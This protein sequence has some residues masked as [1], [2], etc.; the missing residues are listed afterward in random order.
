MQL[1]SG[2]KKTIER[3]Y[4]RERAAEESA[5]V[6]KLELLKIGG[7]DRAER[8]AEAALDHHRL[9]VKFVGTR[10]PKIEMQAPLLMALDDDGTR[11]LVFVQFVGHGVAV[12]KVVALSYGRQRNEGYFL[13][14]PWVLAGARGAV[15]LFRDLV[16]GHERDILDLC[17]YLEDNSTRLQY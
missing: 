16:D 3:R 15:C 2:C 1:F 10:R 14:R 12:E 4:G 7:R 8:P 9:S 5:E 13:A 6:H 17:P 11:A